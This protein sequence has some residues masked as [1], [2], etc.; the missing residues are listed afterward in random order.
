MYM[1]LTMALELAVMRSLRESALKNI[2][3]INY[4]NGVYSVTSSAWARM[5]LRHL[6]TLSLSSTFTN[7]LAIKPP[8]VS[9]S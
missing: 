4:I 3:F 1:S 2:F 7:S 6:S 5:E 9:S 8:A